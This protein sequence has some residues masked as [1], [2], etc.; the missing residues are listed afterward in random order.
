VFSKILKSKKEDAMN[1]KTFLKTALGAIGLGVFASKIDAKI[2]EPKFE[3]LTLGPDGVH[4]WKPKDVF[5][6]PFFNEEKVRRLVLQ[7]QLTIVEDRGPHWN[8]IE[9]EIAPLIDVSI[10]TYAGS[11]ASED[12]ELDRLRT[13]CNRAVRRS[14]EKYDP[15]RGRCFSFVALIARQTTLLNFN[16]DNV[17]MSLEP[18]SPGREFTRQA[19]S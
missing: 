6:D 14:L 18:L 2:T 13:L 10:L 8:A 1:R 5:A 12:P 4:G 3:R 11:L 9:R 15:A 16:N 17:A 7:Y 19:R